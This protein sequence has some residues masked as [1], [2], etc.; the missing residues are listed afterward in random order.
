MIKGYQSKILKIYEKIRER[1]KQN[2]KNR[3]QEVYNK[4]PQIQDIEKNINKLC[5]Q[6]SISAFKP[7]ENREEYL[8]SLREKITDLRIK[9]SEL[10]VSNGY[11]MDYLKTKYSCGKCKDTGFIGHN[12][13]ECYKPKL[14]KLYYENSELKQLLRTNNFKNFKYEYYSSMKINNDIKSPRENTE[15]II[16]I[17]MYFIETFNSSKDNLL[18]FG[19]SGTGKTFLTHCI[20]KELLDRGHLVIYRTAEDLIKNLRETKLQ[21]NYELEDL[22]INCDLLI[23][24]DLGT[25]QVSNFT[26]TELFNLLNKRL[27]KNKKMVIST[28]YDIEVL[29]KAYSERITSRLLGNFTLCKFYGEDIRVKINLN[30]P[31]SPNF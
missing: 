6:L 7:I 14:I 23:I 10:L 4:I 12:R 17:V 29:V 28:N 2:L 9:K 8:K 13:C 16:K 27:L 15:E 25:E 3:K 30:K 24:D 18:F 21:N 26:K 1:E 31:K 19:N 22:L 11:D 20:A 5:I